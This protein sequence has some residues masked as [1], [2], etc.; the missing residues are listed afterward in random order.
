LQILRNAQ[1]AAIREDRVLVEVAGRPQE[2]QND[3]VFILIG[4]NSPEEFLKR[5]GVEM[6]EKSLSVNLER[7]LA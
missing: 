7:T 1:V 6:V 2:V 4:G 5:T 3:Y